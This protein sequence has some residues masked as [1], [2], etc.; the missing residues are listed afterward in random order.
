MASSPEPG[1]LVKLA[2]EH[3]RP[4]PVPPENQLPAPGSLA[5]A[6]L[7]C[8]VSKLVTPKPLA[9]AAAEDVP[10]KA[11]AAAPA[12]DEAVERR[13]DELLE[14]SCELTSGELLLEEELSIIEVTAQLICDDEGPPTFRVGALPADTSYDSLFNMEDKAAMLSADDS[15]HGGHCSSAKG[16][17]RLDFAADGK[18][19]SA[20]QK[21]LM[22][23]EETSF[24]EERP[25][26]ELV[27]ECNGSFQQDR[28]SSRANT[29]APASPQ[30]VLSACTLGGPAASTPSFEKHAPRTSSTFH[31][32]AFSVS[33][34]GRCASPVMRPR[35]SSFVAEKKE[36]DAWTLS[37]FGSQ[38]L[39]VLLLKPVQ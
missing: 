7:E 1:W 14:V 17:R 3:A 12:K 31:E 30:T 19:L 20:Q 13:G 33:G 8:N 16:L 11:E 28:V 34:G 32:A 2:A 15:F 38:V 4:Q 22:T 21:W 29:P 18:G 6:V 26:H 39:D 36:S 37:K 10:A 25:L 9:V 35:P 23:A 27:Q 5:R 24:K